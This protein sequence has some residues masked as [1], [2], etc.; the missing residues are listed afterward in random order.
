MA[1][2][3]H[4][5]ASKFQ[6]DVNE[7]KSFFDASGGR[8]KRLLAGYLAFVEGLA[9][10]GLPPIFEGPH[11]GK[12]LGTT[13]KEF[14]WLTNS[15][16]THYRSFTIPKRNGGERTILA[17]N[18]LL[19]HCQRWIDAFIL[20]NLTVH[21]AAHGY[22]VGR[23]NITNARVHLG[24]VQLLS[25]DISG[26]FE[27]IGEEKIAEIFYAAGYPPAVAF[28]LASL[29][30]YKGHLPQGAASSPQL[31]NII[32]RE[33]DETLHAYAEARKLR[34]SRYVD[35]IVLSGEYVS[36]E[37][38][39]VVEAA[40][41]QIGLALNPDKIRYQRGRKKIVT[42]VSIGSGRLLI[43]RALRRRFRNQAFIAI[44]NLTNAIDADPIALERNLG[45][46]GYWLNV[47]PRNERARLLFMQLKQLA[48]PGG[49]I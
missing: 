38:V 10:K 9:A 35:D 8:Q 42:G 23:S 26:F 6:I 31:S 28:L 32:M 41:E 17:P 1:D 13:S 27:N 34:Y 48:Q 7:W 5:I 39:E 16:E 45:Q 19:L 12:L 22:V 30:S 36:R 40:L 47:E 46:L 29:C 15:P 2:S 3:I 11:L 43:P 49:D 37:D 14:A 25:L 44:K 20:R 4:T 18:P 33:F 24:S 21:D